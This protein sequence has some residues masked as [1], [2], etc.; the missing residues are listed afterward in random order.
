MQISGLFRPVL[1]AALLVS[2]LLPGAPKVQAEEAPPIA[3]IGLVTPPSRST[4]ATLSARARERR[5]MPS[6]VLPGGS[7]Q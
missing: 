7:A 1:L 4:R 3:P 5:L 6:V 2:S